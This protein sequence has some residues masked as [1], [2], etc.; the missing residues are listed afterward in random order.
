MALGVVLLEVV[1][2]I[3]GELEIELLELVRSAG[4]H[5]EVGRRRRVSRR[6]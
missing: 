3:E 4:F 1:A 2:I 6:S 5:S